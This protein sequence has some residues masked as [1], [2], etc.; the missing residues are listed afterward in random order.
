VPLKEARQMTGT[1]HVA[2]HQ[3]DTTHTW[4]TAD[5]TTVR[6]IEEIFREAQATGR[7]VYRQTEDGSGEQVRLATWNPEEHTE[8]FVAP[9]L[10][11]G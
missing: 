8:L 7:L 10:A 6:E 9:R 2:D 5:P 4:D 3:G 1:M 11:G